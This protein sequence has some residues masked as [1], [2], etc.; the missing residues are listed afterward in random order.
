MGRGRNLKSYAILG[1]KLSEAC[2]HAD[3]NSC[4][5]DAA[6]SWC[7]SFA[8]KSKC[9]TL[10]NAKSLPAA[11][12]KCSKM[13]EKK[14]PVIPI[15]LKAD[16][17]SNKDAES[18]DG[19]KCSWCVSAA[20]KSACR[21]PSDAAHLPAAIFTCSNLPSEKKP[22]IPVQL[23][24]ECEGISA[25][26]TCNANAACSWCKS[27]AVKSACRSLA[28]AKALPSAIF[29]C[30]KINEKWI[31]VIPVQ[32]KSD[33][34]SNAD[35]KSCNA[36]KCS[37]CVSAAVRSACRNPSDAAHLPAAVFTCSNLPSL[38]EE[39]EEKKHSSFRGFIARMFGHKGGKHHG[40][41]QDGR[42]HRGGEDKPEGR[43]GR[44]GGR[45]HKQ[46]EGQDEQEGPR[47]HHGPPRVQ[48]SM[49]DNDMVILGGVP[50]KRS[51]A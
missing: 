3:E 10:A 35:A 32:F 46:Q 40:R 38:D 7:S 36:A 21:N 24:D 45:H 23:K 13:S 16:C 4:N 50:F 33:C 51:F 2:S 49:N 25:E 1:S 34:E 28:N 27:A 48:S 11:V 47:N 18:C 6:C 41:Q 37:W 22:V 42:H 5:A 20:V 19:A 26:G 8:V 30:S 14:I 43:H 44:H 39:E 15:Q 17:E 29:S 31:P 9:N 12:F